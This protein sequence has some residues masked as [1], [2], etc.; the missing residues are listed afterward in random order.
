M[1]LDS[2]EGLGNFREQL[3]FDI[4]IAINLNICSGVSDIILFVH[5]STASN[6]PLKT[7]LNS[8]ISAIDQ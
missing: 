1:E 7:F 2:L 3:C 5:L 8:I 6:Y 4:H